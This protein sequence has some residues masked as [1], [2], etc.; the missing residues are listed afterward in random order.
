MF[1]VCHFSTRQ[2]FHHLPPTRSKSPLLL[3]KLSSH[4]VQGAPV[5]EPVDL[6]VIEGVVDREFVCA[7]ILALALHSNKLVKHLS[8]P[9]E[10]MHRNKK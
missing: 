10:T 4:G 2:N 5:L 1:H 8:V 3:G 7:A 9:V 6:V